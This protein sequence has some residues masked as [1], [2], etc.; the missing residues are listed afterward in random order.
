MRPFK[1]KIDGKVF[2]G[3]APESYKEITLRQYIG[4]ETNM[5]VLEL[6]ELLTGIPKKDLENYKG[7]LEKHIQSF[8]YI[9][10]LPEISKLKRVKL[11]GHQLP[12]DIAF[13]RFGQKLMLEQAIRENEDLR[14]VIPLAIAIYLTPLIY[15]EFDSSKVEEVR[16]RLLNLPA[17][18]CVNH[19][20][21]FLKALIDYKTILTMS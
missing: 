19:A 12:K 21:F 18:Q 2:E 20:V 14:K 17:I 8:T 3:M 16:E 9:Y 15:G 6:M 5:D 4:L 7:D 13:E 10:S 1:L 11:L